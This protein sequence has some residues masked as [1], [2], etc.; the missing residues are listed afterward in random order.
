MNCKLCQ[1]ALPDLLLEAAA[2][3]ARAAG[4]AKLAAARAHIATCSACAR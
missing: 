1:A 2:P 3:A 4:S